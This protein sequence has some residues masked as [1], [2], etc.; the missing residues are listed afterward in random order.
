MSVKNV[1]I[2]LISTFTKLKENP[3][4]TSLQRKADELR[5]EL[6]ELASTLAHTD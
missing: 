2:S 6:I 4:D 5:E 3:T 1:F